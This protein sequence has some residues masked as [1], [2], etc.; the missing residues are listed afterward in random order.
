MEKE[1]GKIHEYEQRKALY[2][3]DIGVEV[4]PSKYLEH[5]DGFQN[6][7]YYYAWYNKSEKSGIW[8][9]STNKVL[10]GESKMLSQCKTKEEAERT[11][12][13]IN[14]FIHFLIENI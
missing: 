6:L 12:G 11:A 10:Y 9:I 5:T 7:S 8:E 13:A 1:V 3:T 14:R 2:K 4:R